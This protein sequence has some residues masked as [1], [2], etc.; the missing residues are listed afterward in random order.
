LPRPHRRGCGC[1]PKRS[2]IAAGLGRR[3]GVVGGYAD[4][5]H[6]ADQEFPAHGPL[7]RGRRAPAG[8]VARHA[9]VSYL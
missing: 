1:S 2:T 4:I 8:A 3:H 5:A 9:G 7:A 6:L